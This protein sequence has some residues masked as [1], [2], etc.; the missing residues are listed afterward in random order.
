MSLKQLDEFK[1]WKVDAKTEILLKQ[2]TAVL[3]YEAGFD[4]D[5]TLSQIE[6]GSFVDSRVENEDT[7]KELDP[8]VVSERNQMVFKSV[9][10][11]LVE[12]DFLG[13]FD[14]DSVTEEELKETIEISQFY[15]KQHHLAFEK[16]KIEDLLLSLF[17]SARN[18]YF[19]TP[20]L[21]FIVARKH[22]FA[23]ALRMCVDSLNWR[24]NVHPVDTY[25]L[26]GDAK[27][28]LSK[29]NP[30][31]IEAFKLGQAYIRGRDK[32]G[33]P[34]VVVRV[35]K[36]LRHN[37][38]DHDF[39]RFICI[40]IETVRLK[41]QESKGVNKG[42]IL[43]DMTDFL[44]QNADFHAIKFLAQS[45]EANYP[46]Y[47]GSILIHNAPWV[48]NT[49]WAVIK[50]WLDPNVVSKIHFTKSSSLPKFISEE[51]IP[52]WLGGSDSYEP[53]YVPPTED[54]IPK[55]I[56]QSVVSV[57]EKRHDIC[58]DFVQSTINWVTAKN[59]EDSYN[60]LIQRLKYQKQLA[61]NYAELDPHIRARG[62]CDR[63][64]EIDGVCL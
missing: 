5:V 14:V 10:N 43:F 31:I 38:P 28:Y 39:E 64:G 22:N 37:C 29:S 46:E 54:C 53:E 41:L 8:P 52:Q 34:I 2:V 24:I 50:N 26:E 13:S 36:H 27:M 45:F 18:D 55:T 35:K 42:T 62:P 58:I 1:G 56:D 40:I 49:V 23:D 48:F 4:I 15:P 20:L 3:L 12:G 51:H 11:R 57:I 59:K 30:Q 6:N 17:A 7:F 61:E 60:Y 47:L 63:N 21:R 25:F 33:Q 32:N 44:L 16:Y 9:R 19:D